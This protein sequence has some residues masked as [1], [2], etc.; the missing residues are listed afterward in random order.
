MIRAA[1]GGV[2]RATLREKPPEFLLAARRE[3]DDARATAA[4]R[5]AERVEAIEQSRADAS[6]EVVAACAPVEARAAHRAARARGGK[7]ETQL[8]AEFLARFR[9]RELGLVVRDP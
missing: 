9:E 8:A 4:L 6:R 7:I 5:P 3:I 1:C 2:M